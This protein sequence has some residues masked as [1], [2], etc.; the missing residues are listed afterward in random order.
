MSKIVR[1]PLLFDLAKGNME[2]LKRN[3]SH[4]KKEYDNKWVIIHD[5]KVVGS[6]DTF[7]EILHD[8]RKYEP[9]SVVVKYIHSKDIAMFF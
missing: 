7:D 5:Q 9:S 1:T 2:W 8:A 4:L 3:Y 6:G